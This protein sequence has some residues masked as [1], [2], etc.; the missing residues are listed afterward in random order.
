MRESDWKRMPEIT[1][2]SKMNE[3]DL[4][5]YFLYGKNMIAQKQ[6]KKLGQEISYYEVIGKGVGGHIEYAPVFDLLERDLLKKG[7]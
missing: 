1:D 5:D 4:H 2:E 3:L 7:D 6:T